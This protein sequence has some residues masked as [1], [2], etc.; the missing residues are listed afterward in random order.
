MTTA[1][2][3]WSSLTLGTPL[4]Q[5]L[6]PEAPTASEEAPAQ[7]LEPGS[8][9]APQLLQHLLL[10]AVHLEDRSP[11]WLAGLQDP[12][13]TS[14]TPP[15]VTLGSPSLQLKVGKDLAGQASQLPHR[16]KGSTQFN[17]PQCRTPARLKSSPRAD[18]GAREGM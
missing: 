6:D 13:T 7:G 1:A 16:P 15:G 11:G 18:P 9:A 3:V 17:A 10:L 8:C 14:L 2:V 4:H 12:R 5:V